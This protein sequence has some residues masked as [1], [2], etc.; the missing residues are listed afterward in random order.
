MQKRIQQAI[1]DHAARECPREACG[2]IVRVSDVLRYIECRNMAEQ[3]N[4]FIMDP[5]DYLAASKLGEITA[6]V[7]SHPNYSPTPSEA[8]RVACE[9]SGLPWHIYSHPGGE[10]A[11][12]APTGYKSP[13]YGRIW[14]HGVLDCYTFVRDWYMEERGIELPDFHRNETWWKKGENIYVENFAKAGFVRVVDEQPQP[15]DVLLMQVLANVPNHGGIYLDGDIVAHHLYN[16]LSSR[17]VWGGYYKKHT[18]HILRY[19]G[20][21][22][23]NNSSRGT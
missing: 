10:W 8:D 3:D 14:V 15:G 19:V 23:E 20:P 6:V 1:A 21:N 17:E 18:T 11:Y 2:L 13:L 9:A 22:K 12:L 4:F 7:H 5:R 16:R